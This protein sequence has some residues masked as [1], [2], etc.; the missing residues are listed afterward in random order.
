METPLTILY[1]AN[2]AGDLS[3]LPAL[4]TFIRQVKA[5]P[6][7]D[8]DTVRICAAEMLPQRYLLV[9]LGGACAAEVWHC[10]VTGGRS[11]LMVLDA[12]GYRAANTTGYLAE[13][14]R[15]KLE[16]NLM[17]LVPIDAMH[18]WSDDTLLITVD[19]TGASQ[20]RQAL[21]L[22]LAPALA[23]D[24]EQGI[25][26]LAAVQSGQLGMVRVASTNGNG[27]LTITGRAI[28]NMPPQTHPDPTIAGTVDFVISEAQFYQRQG[29]Q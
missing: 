13:D 24:F 18:A 17:Q 22:D 9:D 3:L 7:D 23:T 25:L 29:R 10:A 14:S 28:F 16:D 2:I 21:H 27:Q 11:T 6:A 19:A 8:E 26:R 15:A 5:Q 12:M 20:S 1:T 4:H